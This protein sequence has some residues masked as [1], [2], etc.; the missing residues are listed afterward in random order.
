MRF[1]CAVR[2][3]DAQHDARELGAERED[4]WQLRRGFYEMP[5]A[6]NVS[7][8]LNDCLLIGLIALR[9]ISTRS[10]EWVVYCWQ[11]FPGISPYNEVV[12]G[13]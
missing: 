13:T 9:E 4:A 7:R 5:E 1:D 11:F 10:N 8:L 2:A 12:L 6:V 3:T